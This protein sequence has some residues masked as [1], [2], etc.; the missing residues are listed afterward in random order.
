MRLHLLTVTAFGPFAGTETVDF[1]ALGAAGLFLLHGPTGAGKTSVLD[2]VV[3]A[4]YG[5]VPG[6]RQRAG[7]LRSD[8]A[9]PEV[10][11]AVALE[12]TVR[13]RRL[14]ITR[15]AAW[16]RPKRRGGGTTREQARVLVEELA[17]AGDGR[18]VAT[19]STRLDE[20]GQLLHDLLGMNA[21]EFCQVVL[22]PQGQ[23][24]EFL[25]ADADARRPLLEQLFSTER[26]SAVEAELADARRA[27][28]QHLDVAHA[29]VTQLLARVVE[30]AGLEAVPEDVL[31]DL[32]VDTGAGGGAIG[33]SERLRHEALVGLQERRQ[34][35]QAAA[36]ALEQARHSYDTATERAEDQHRAEQVRIR[37]TLLE[38]RLAARPALVE[39][40]RLARAAEQL[41]PALDLLD[42]AEEA[43]QELREAEQWTRQHLPEAL[44][45]ASP[46]RLRAACQRTRDELA[47]LADLAVDGATEDRLAAALAAEVDAQHER[48][49]ALSD[50]AAE[51]AHVSARLP[52]IDA[53]LAPA[54][55]EAAEVGRL[56]AE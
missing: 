50:L 33:W 11:T 48:E 28:Q 13:G 1:D 42:R 55:R 43:V 8:H 18:G 4:L 41:V 19:L 21:E 30:A 52:E 15:Q 56:R 45:T 7:A 25:R 38:A 35:E 17:V 24:A 47:V 23:F 51:L 31:D 32:G 39:E 44:Q 2:A 40:L 36:T 49:E 3:F 46:A 54:R 37:A 16:E 12:V 27:A 14:R 53:G 20:A 34:A 29:E 6:A 22:L 26:F 10:Q 5:V 9:D